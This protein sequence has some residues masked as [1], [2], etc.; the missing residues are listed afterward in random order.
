MVVYTDTPFSLY[1]PCPFRF[2]NIWHSHDLFLSCVKDACIRNDSVSGLL[3]LAIRLKRTKVALRTWNKNVFGRVGE[4]LQALEER[5][6]VLENQLQSGFLRRSK[7]ITWLLKSSGV[8]PCDLSELIK[9][10]IS[11]VDNNFLCL[12]LT[13]EEVKR[14]VLSIPKDSI[15]GPD[16]FGSEFYMSCWDIVK[17]DIMDAAKDFF[18]GTPLS[19]FYSSSFIVLIPKVDNPSSFDK[20]RSISLC[21]VAYKFFSKIIVFRLSDVVQKLVSHEQG[22]FIPGRSI[23]ENIMF[24]QET[25]HS[26]HKKMTGGNV[27]VKLDMAKAYDRVNWSF[28]LEVFKAFGFSDSFSKLIK[29]CVESPWFSV[30]MNE[31][32]K[33]FFQPARGLRQ[34]DPF[35]PL[36]FIIMEDVLTRCTLWYLWDI[37]EDLVAELEG[38]NFIVLHQYREGNSATDF[39][40]REGILGVIGKFGFGFVILAYKDEFEIYSADVDKA[41]IP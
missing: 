31:T 41:L 17:E 9:S 27:M 34:G 20:F 40:A 18:R 15:P 26:L 19:R 23:F 11:N 16:G 30:M 7:P 14:A 4:N 37:L 5:M 38:V 25:V 3:K 28:L 22:A 36:L 8:D 29:K 6:E 13:E 24:A 1:S 32:F 33:E 21:S 39:H 35:S 12:E 10:Q 2:L